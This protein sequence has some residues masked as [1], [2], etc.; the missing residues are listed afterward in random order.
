[1][2]LAGQLPLGI[3]PVISLFNL[4]TRQHDD[5]INDGMKPWKP[6][7]AIPKVASKR[8]PFISASSLTGYVLRAVVPHLRARGRAIV[9]CSIKG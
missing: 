3:N 5:E 8:T 6:V 2:E 7:L 9:K 4:P 1:M